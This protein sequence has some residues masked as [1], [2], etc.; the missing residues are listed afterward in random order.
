MS[1]TEPSRVYAQ[2][3]HLAARYSVSRA[4]IWRWV[5]DGRIPKPV[6]L[7]PGCTR[8]RLADLEKFEQGEQ[9]RA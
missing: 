1:A 7:S 5:Q 4:T 9:K 6:K 8:W 2:D 3:T